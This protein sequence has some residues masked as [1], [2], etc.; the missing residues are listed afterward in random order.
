MS[1]LKAGMT[2]YNEWLGTLSR[3]QYARECRKAYQATEYGVEYVDQ[4]GDV[5]ETDFRDT[6]REAE[7]VYPEASRG[8][9]DGEAG[10]VTLCKTRSWYSG[11]DVSLEDT[12]T[13]TL[14]SREL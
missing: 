7:A 3:S 2:K 6:L 9:H 14:D 5:I 12:E 13:E 1:P 8:D 4:N 11:V 10:S